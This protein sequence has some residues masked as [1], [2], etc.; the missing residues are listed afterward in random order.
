MYFYCPVVVHPY[1][2]FVSEFGENIDF[3]TYNSDF[4]P[5][6][7]AASLEQVITS[8]TYE[9]YCRN[10]H[11]RVKEYTWDKY[12]DWTFEELAKVRPEIGG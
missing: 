12:I 9:S 1:G 6:G 4:T 3:G 10:A 7:V 11:E 8:P 5:E 2:H